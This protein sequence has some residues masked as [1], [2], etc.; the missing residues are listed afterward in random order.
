MKFNIQPISGTSANSSNNNA[1]SQQSQSD[2]QVQKVEREL[3]TTISV[4][5]TRKGI[6]DKSVEV[7]VN[8]EIKE[9]FLSQVQVGQPWHALE[10]NFI[11]KWFVCLSPVK[12]D[13]SRDSKN[14]TLIMGA[15]N[16]LQADSMESRV[17]KPATAPRLPSKVYASDA[18]EVEDVE[19]LERR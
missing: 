19:L 5:P 9:T 10:G 6:H 4:V 18:A 1:G 12:L 14:P 2:R 13:Y 11:N 8:G 15:M 7:W 16:V 3:T 17:H